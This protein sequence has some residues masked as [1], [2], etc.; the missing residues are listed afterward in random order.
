ME[1][2]RS[3]R[4]DLFAGTPTLEAF[5]LLVYKLA[6]S[7]GGYAPRK[8]LMVMDV[9]RAFLHAQV[10]REIYIELPEEAKNEDD[11]DVDGKLLKSLYGTR[12]APQNWQAYVDSLMRELGFLPGVAHPCVYRHTVR[13]L[14][15]VVH[16]DDFACLGPP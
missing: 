6:S 13:D 10:T 14:Q 9:K 12:D 11:G 5:K 16:V 15:V 8:C 2:A 4:D 3:K 7:N 1:I